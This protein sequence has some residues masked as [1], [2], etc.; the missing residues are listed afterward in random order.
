MS[1]FQELS[2]AIHSHWGKLPRILL[3]STFS[4]SFNLFSSRMD[5]SSQFQLA[6]NH[7][8]QK[9]FQSN[10][11]LSYSCRCLEKDLC[12]LNVVRGSLPVTIIM[13]TWYVHGVQNYKTFLNPSSLKR[14]IK[15]SH[16]ALV[17]QLKLCTIGTAYYF[18]V[19]PN[20]IHVRDSSTRECPE[21]HV[22][23]Q[24][25]ELATT[26]A[27]TLVQQAEEDWKKIVPI[28]PVIK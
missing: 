27:M 4:Y 9:P 21:G 19:Q 1:S 24:T 28:N 18:A 23:S 6:V 17:D 26:E 8:M 2:R 15:N 25:V 7:A 14:H 22:C 12:V 5:C 20:D 10:K 13:S 11:F 16:A 3:C